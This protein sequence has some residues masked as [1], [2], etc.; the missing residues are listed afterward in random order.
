MASSQFARLERLSDHLRIIRSAGANAEIAAFGQNAYTKPRVSSTCSWGI[1]VFPQRVLAAGLSVE[2]LPQNTVGRRRMHFAAKILSLI[3]AVVVAAPAAAQTSK[4]ILRERDVAIVALQEEVPQISNLTPHL[5]INI[6]GH[7]AAIRAL[8]FSPDSHRL[9]TGG[10]DKVVQ[11]W[12]LPGAGGSM[13]KGIVRERASWQY[14]HTLRWEIARGLRGVIYALAVSPDGDTVAVGG[15]GA[16]GTIGEIVWLNADNGAFEHVD[17]KGHRIAVTSLSYSPDGRW[18]V[19]ADSQGEVRLHDVRRRTP[20]REI[21]RDGVFTN[22]RPV[23]MAGNAHALFAVFAKKVRAKKPDGSEAEVASFNLQSYN[24]IEERLVG[25]IGPVHN[26][27]VSAL[28]GCAAGLAASGDGGRNLYLHRLGAQPHSDRLAQGHVVISLA[29]SRDGKYLAAGTAGETGREPPQLQIWDTA[30]RRLIHSRRTP[31]GVNAIA[32]SADGRWLAHTGSENHGVFV[33]ELADGVPVEASLRELPGGQRITEVAAIDRVGGMQV[34]FD[35]NNDESFGFDPAELDTRP[36]SL[37]TPRGRTITPETFAGPWT[38]DI[39]P[40]RTVIRLRQRGTPRGVIQLDPALHGKITN[41]RAWCF[42]GDDKGEPLALAIGTE[43]ECGIFVYGLAAT[44]ECP[45]LRYYRGH[46]GDVTTLSAT[47]DGRYLVSGSADGTVRYWRLSGLAGRPIPR[48]WGAE[49]ATADS[50]LRVQDI[51]DTSPLFHKGV[52]NGDIIEKIL[53]TEPGRGGRPEVFSAHEPATMYEQLRL[54]TWRKEVYFVLRRGDSQ[55]RVNV[56]GGWNHLLA[57]FPLR[58]D[59]I[60]WHPSGYYTCSPGGERL[61]GWQVQTNELSN[62]VEERETPHFYPA[63]RFH[64]RLFQPDELKLLLARGSLP[65]PQLEQQQTYQPPA[66]PIVE[67]LEPAQSPVAVKGGTVFVRARA[68]AQGRAP[69]SSLRL[70]VNGVEAPQYSKA[71]ERVRVVSNTQDWVEREWTVPLVSG[72]H[73]IAVRADAGDLYDITRP[74]IVNYEVEKAKRT[75]HLLVI[76][77]N[78]YQNDNVPDLAYAV[79]DGSR[80]ESIFAAKSKGLY[81]DVSVTHVRN[82]DACRKQILTA[83]QDVAEHVQMNDLVVV[84]YSGHGFRTDDDQFYFVCHDADQAS[85]RDKGLSADDL[86][87]FCKAIGSKSA[88]M[89]LLVDACHSGAMKLDNLTRELGRDEYSVAMMASS[90]GSQVSWEDASFGGGAFTQALYLGLFDGEAETPFAKD[91]IVDTKE[92]GNF[93]ELAVNIRLLSTIE[94]SLRK[95]YPM[96]KYPQY[97]TDGSILQTPVSN[98]TSLERIPLTALGE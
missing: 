96:E 43:M 78:D 63:V 45:L 93:V 7:T 34:R 92:L 28:A 22:I 66:P 94:P 81:D 30:T 52:R 89:L 53:W 65:K 5:A 64:K 24:V 85:I 83:M 59:W 71:I 46:Q 31:R 76:G 91:G 19:S 39:S 2:S 11:V 32:F 86:K 3:L 84:F 87:G 42:V 73:T 49:L 12:Q 54:L 18:L 79:S 23:A 1:G 98:F 36:L 61:V 44:G 29:F 26:E 80:V 95:K 13:P 40:D 47:R 82:A 25:Q 55:W 74:A 4:G 6:E 20:S 60:A 17:G 68:K 57:V 48:R 38:V 9:Y 21:H 67:L 58:D 75:L 51:T 97:Y 37:G 10:M 27:Y 8:A 56:V 41:N 14:S 77:V 72:Q 62:D 33:A 16:R 50:G 70:L 90:R 15:N 69:I 88:K 35:T